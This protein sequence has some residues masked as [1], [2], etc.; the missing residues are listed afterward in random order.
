MNFFILFYI[1]ALFTGFALGRL[2]DK[3][4]GPK[5]TPHHW[6]YGLF[7]VVLGTIFYYNFFSLLLIFFGIG[8]FISDLN[9]FF[10][11]RIYGIDVPHK[12]KF[13]SIQ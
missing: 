1:L 7:L 2:G 11:L 3:Y 12:W 10:H 5:N 9:D 4:F 8:H 6:I 13:W